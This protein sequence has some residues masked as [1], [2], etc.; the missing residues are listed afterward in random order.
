MKAVT[1]KKTS[2]SEREFQ[3]LIGLVDH[4]IETGIPVGSATLQEGAF[5]HLSSAT[6]RNYFAHL[7]SEGY[8]TQQHASGG[9][10]PTESAYRHYASQLSDSNSTLPGAQAELLKTLKNR[11]TSEITAYLQEAA[12]KLSEI[13]Q[14]AAFI[15]APRFDHDYIDHMRLLPLDNSR[16]LG[17]ILT[18]FGVVQTEVLPVELKLNAFSVKRI[19]DYFRWRLTQH[20][21]PKNLEPEEEL[22]AQQL[23]NEMIVRYVIR[24]SN[25]TEEDLYRT[26]FSKLLAYPEFRDAAPLSDTLGILENKHTLRLLLKETSSKG[27]IRCWIGSDFIPLTSIKQHCTVLTIP[28]YINKTIV[29]SLGILG[30]M[31]MPYKERYAQ[32][33]QFSS[34]ISETLTQNI[35]KFKISFRQPDVETQFLKKEEQQLL[36]GSQT[37]LLED[38]RHI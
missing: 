4:Y 15:S 13:T 38:K 12:E 3:V 36:T 26:G 8:L 30:P 28:Y 31:R 18:N 22:L 25:F 24:Y 7:E 2:K 14:C 35:Y 37:R 32:I 21:E 9:R 1:Q 33:R 27:Q 10:I 11:E 23:Y 20:N 17:V 5:S 29:G 6:I 34:V 19:E 16:C